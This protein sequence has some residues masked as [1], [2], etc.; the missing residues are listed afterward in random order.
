MAW[1]V[2]CTCLAPARVAPAG[3][4]QD[5]AVAVGDIHGEEPISAGRGRELYGVGEGDDGKCG[6]GGG[7]EGERVQVVLRELELAAADVEVGWG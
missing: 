3:K 5:V 2:A 4:A 7:A 1:P 6:D